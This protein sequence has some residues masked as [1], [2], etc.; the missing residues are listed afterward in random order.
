MR[1]FSLYALVLTLA[2]PASALADQ[3]TVFVP[4]F[5][6]P[7]LAGMPGGSTASGYTP[8]SPGVDVAPQQSPVQVVG[9]PVS[10]GTIMTFNATGTAAYG[11][12]STTGP[13]LKFSGPDGKLYY[14]NYIHHLAGAQSGL[15]DIHTP[16]NALLGVFL[17][18]GRPDNTAAPGTLDVRPGGNVAGGLD[19]A[20]LNPALKQ[21]FFIGDGLDGVANQ[22]LIVAPA[23]ATRLFLGV[24]DGWEWVGNQGGY[25]VR[26]NYPSGLVPN[27]NVPEPGSLALLAI[28]GAGLWGYA[29]RR[30]R[31]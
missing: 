10:S 14:T 23:G 25:Y 26:V 20:M 29:L 16:I 5:A 9:L 17:D 30:R 19:Y 27:A 21:V 18:A 2:F 6:D 11:P 13:D 24:A 3:I 1:P 8:G 12:A 28:G 22:Q 15:S 31:R 7:W 4:G